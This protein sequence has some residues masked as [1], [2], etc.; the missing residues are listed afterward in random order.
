MA[1]CLSTTFFISWLNSEG[2]RGWREGIKLPGR[3]QTVMA[4]L[5]PSLTSLV[6]TRRFRDILQKPVG[7]V[8]RMRKAAEVRYMNDYL[9][10]SNA[11]CDRDRCNFCQN[12]EHVFLFICM[13]FKFA[14]I[15]FVA[16]LAKAS[17]DNTVSP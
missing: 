12:E 16:T 14:D 11:A 7:R 8:L 5:Y 9:C 4:S 17:K 3:Y 1:G 6:S 15:H 10:T 2:C 13:P